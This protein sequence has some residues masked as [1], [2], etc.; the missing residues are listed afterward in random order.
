MGNPG[1]YRKKE[2]VIRGIDAQPQED[3]PTTFTLEIVSRNEA[4]KL[5][6]KKTKNR[7]SPGDIST[8]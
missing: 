5:N 1:N 7:S 3:G 2:I 6:L 4:V 8:E